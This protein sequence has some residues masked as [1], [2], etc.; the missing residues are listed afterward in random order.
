MPHAEE[1]LESSAVLDA[2]GVPQG[3][4]SEVNSTEGEP[5][6]GAGAEEPSTGV[7]ATA[8]AAARSVEEEESCAA[9]SAGLPAF[10][11]SLA[12]WLGEDLE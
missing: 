8:G 9:E 2:A 3:E 11:T 4:P 5:Q 12:D 10:A 6:A 1:V 7:A